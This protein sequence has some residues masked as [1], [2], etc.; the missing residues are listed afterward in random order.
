MKDIFLTP[1]NRSTPL[2]TRQGSF[3]KNDLSES[4][5]RS[6]NAFTKECHSLQ[7]N[8]ADG[9]LQDLR[10]NDT[11]I[12][13]K[14]PI[15]L[16]HPLGSSPRDIIRIQIDHCDSGSILT[17]GVNVPSGW[18]HAGAG[19]D[20]QHQ[21]DGLGL[22]PIVDVLDRVSGKSLSEPDHPWAQQPIAFGAFG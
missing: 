10:D 12:T 9:A 20:H 18:I 1:I 22:N 15:S 13:L 14:E 2:R 5:C 7:S 17:S 21:V 11:G 4:F 16:S 6:C 3:P 8:L 19:A